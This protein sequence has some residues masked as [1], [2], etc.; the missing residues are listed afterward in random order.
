MYYIMYYIYFANNCYYCAH[1][2]TSTYNVVESV[3]AAALSDHDTN[4]I[5]YQR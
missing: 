5:N 2:H 4:G 1:A 3:V